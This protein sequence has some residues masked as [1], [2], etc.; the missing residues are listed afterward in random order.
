MGGWTKDAGSEVSLCLERAEWGG[1]F[2]VDELEPGFLSGDRRPI[3]R[4]R[5]LGLLGG[6]R[7]GNG[8]EWRLRVTRLDT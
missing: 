4:F 3:S 8:A 7:G 6:E 2:L 5:G 1:G